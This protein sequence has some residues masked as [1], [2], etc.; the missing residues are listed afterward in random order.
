MKPFYHVFF[1]TPI[2]PK[3]PIPIKWLTKATDWNMLT[4]ATDSATVNA[5]WKTTRRFALVL[6]AKNYSAFKKIFFGQKLE[7]FKIDPGNEPW[8]PSKNPKKP[9]FEKKLK[10]L[11]KDQTFERTVQT[12]SATHCEIC[13]GSLHH[14]VQTG[15]SKCVRYRLSQGDDVDEMVNGTSSLYQAV[16]NGHAEIVDILVEN[17]ANLELKTEKWCINCTGWFRKFLIQV[18]TGFWLKHHIWYHSYNFHFF[19]FFRFQIDLPLVY[20][21]LSHIFSILN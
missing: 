20:F 16:R 17:D 11:Q 18:G 6:L 2:H 12:G 5:R 3:M 9:V 13:P 1:R 14:S 10:P 21:S 15:N 8:K 4:C 7:I 19:S